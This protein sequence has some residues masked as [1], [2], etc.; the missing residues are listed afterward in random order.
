MARTKGI[1]ARVAQD[2]IVIE[3]EGAKYRHP[4]LNSLP[5]NLSLKAANTR[6]T[7]KGTAFHSKHAVCP[8]FYQSP[9]TFDDITYNSV[10]QAFQYSRALAGN[11][12]VIAQR[13]L[14]ERDPLGMQTMS[15]RG[16]WPCHTIAYERNV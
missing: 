9:F 2:F 3:G 6:Q 13:I 7:T 11:S 5:G 10:E 8:N 14:R 4:D 12:A 1:E 16:L 15:F